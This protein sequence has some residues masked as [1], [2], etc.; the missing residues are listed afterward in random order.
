[1][2]EP[3]DVQAFLDA[4]GR[5]IKELR[6]EKKMTQLDLAVASGM[7]IRQIQRIEAG[8]INTSVGNVW[9]IAMAL[10]INLP[11]LVGV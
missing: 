1:M 8:H 9:E 2:D 3:A 5:R 4:L 11:Y 7:D 6:Q 10:D